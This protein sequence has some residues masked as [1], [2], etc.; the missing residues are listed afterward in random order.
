MN[1]KGIEA[2]CGLYLPPDYVPNTKYPLVIQTHGFHS[3]EFSMDGR[4]EYSG[5][6]ARPLA[7]RGIVV[8]QA[9]SFKNPSDLERV[10]NDGSL[11]ATPEQRVKHFDALV[12]ENAIEQLDRDHVIDPARVGIIGFSRSVSV[13]LYVLTHSQHS[14]AAAMLLDGV[15]GGYFENMAFQSGAFDG[16]ALNGGKPP[17]GEGLKQWLQESPSF[18]LDKIHT[19]IELVAITSPAVLELWEWFAGLHLQGK[20]V[21]MLEIP[22]ASHVIVKPWERRLAQQLTLDWF[23]FWLKGEEDPNPGKAEQYVRWR[24][25]RKLHEENDR[26]SKQGNPA[27]LMN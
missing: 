10:K 11:G 2:L 4:S 25:L 6:A 14:F 12:Y 15:G 5:F 22:Y 17:F 20:P 7:A 1:I 8:L 16:D 18:N 23:S 9:S 13:V 21:D 27:P 26:K 3:L 19:P 24:E